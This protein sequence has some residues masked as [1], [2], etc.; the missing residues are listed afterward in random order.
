MIMDKYILMRLA[1]LGLAQYVE[2]LKAA[3]LSSDEINKR[4]DIDRKEV[5]KRHPLDLGKG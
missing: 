2:Y 1:L 4:F 5:L 3:G